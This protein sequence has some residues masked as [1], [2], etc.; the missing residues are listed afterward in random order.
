MIQTRRLLRVLC[1]G[2]ASVCLPAAAVEAQ[3]DR[4]NV[5]LMMADDLANEDLSCYGSQRIQ[6]PRLD[7]LAEPVALDEAL[8]CGSDLGVGLAAGV[9]AA[10]LLGEALFSRRPKVC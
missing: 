7:A 2:G 6:T 5:I 1:I 3:T 8:L 4:P 10:G 9:G